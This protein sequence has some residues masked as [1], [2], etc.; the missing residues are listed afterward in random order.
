MPLINMSVLNM[1]CISEVRGVG[2]GKLI[3][4]FK[5]TL[6]ISS[7]CFSNLVVAKASKLLENPEKMEYIRMLKF[8][9]LPTNPG[10]NQSDTVYDVSHTGATPLL[11][12]PAS[13]TAPVDTTYA[14]FSF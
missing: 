1:D 10:I 9:L 8:T 3:E 7:K 6:C 12:N 5:I 2:C 14:S 11:E 4:R 13:C